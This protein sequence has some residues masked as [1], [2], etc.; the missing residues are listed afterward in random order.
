MGSTPDFDAITVDRLRE[1]G[2]LKWSAFPGTIGAF[3]AEADYGVAP[4]IARALHDAVDRGLF[5]YLPAALGAELAEATA[6]WQRSAYGWS[7]PAERVHPLGDVVAGL[8]AA[9][10]FFS[11]PGAPVILPTPAYMPFL[12]VPATLGRETIE[13]PLLDG[14]AG[15]AFDLEGIDRAFR[16]GAR[17]LILCNPYNPVGRV[18][19]REE[20][21]ALAEVV[22]RNGGRV[23]S[24]EIHAP[25][26]YPGGRHI[27]YAS[28]SAATAAHTVTATSASKAWN[29]PGL[30]CAQLILSNEGDEELWEREGGF[31]EHGASNLGVVANIAAYREG[32]EWLDA[33]IAYTDRNRHALGE[34]LAEAAPGMRYRP[35]E[36]TYIAWLDARELGLDGSTADFF[37]EEAGVTMTDGAA[38]GQPGRGFLRFVIATP[39]PILED[40][41]TRMG[42]A[43]R[44]R[45]A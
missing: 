12:T 41:V 42:R 14:A 44:R 23:F 10:E 28:L 11:E 37:R 7:V 27:P 22:E 43:L 20:L 18:F 45:A 34:L 1:I 21:E 26:V 24:D 8:R 19:R 31:L 16:A 25:F 5:G 2:G 33:A 32:R 36:G 9:I 30:K 6:E 29:L 3:V 13:V 38:C 15:Y 17:L 4:P 40:A 35:P 39:R